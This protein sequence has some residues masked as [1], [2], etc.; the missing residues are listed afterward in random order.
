MKLLPYQDLTYEQQLELLAQLVHPDLVKTSLKVKGPFTSGD[1]VEDMLRRIFGPDNVS[2]KIN[3]QQNVTI[4]DIELY[5]QGIITLSVTF[6]NGVTTT[7][8]GI[9]VWPLKASEGHDLTN[10]PSERYETVVKACITDAIKNA[11]EKLGR[12][13]RPITDDT[14]TGYLGRL[15]HEAGEKANKNPTTTEDKRA[16]VFGE[17][18][19]Q[20]APPVASG[21][22]NGHAK[23]QPPVP[24][25]P[26]VAQPN[27]QTLRARWSV[28][29]REL[30]KAKIQV[31][32]IA[33][34]VTI[35]DLQAKIADAEKKL[36]EVIPA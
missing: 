33:G 7:H 23:E 18:E 11:A 19:K 28:L 35:P 10:T 2:I 6:A 26:P 15:A 16:A 22:G 12:C 32:P 17:E 14:L 21:N 36:A 20:T 34:G 1:Y 25:V 27:M 4:S 30:Q 24:P 31:A 9:G 5:A 13:F 29:W 8:D 3:G